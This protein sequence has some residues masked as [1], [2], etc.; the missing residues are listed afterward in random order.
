MHPTRSPVPLY[1]LVL[2]RN[3]SSYEISSITLRCPYSTDAGYTANSNTRQ[4]IPGTNCAEMRFL[5]FNFGRMALPGHAYRAAMRCHRVLFPP[6]SISY[7]AM[8]LLCHV[9]Y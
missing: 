8:P 4:R 6:L 3:F 1:A 7:R 2:N 5:V 9:R